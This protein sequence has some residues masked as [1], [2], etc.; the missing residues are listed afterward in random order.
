MDNQLLDILVDPVTKGPYQRGQATP[1]KQKGV[2][3]LDDD[4]NKK[5]S[6]NKIS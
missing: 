4:K 3:L 6:A 1:W 5:R 2:L